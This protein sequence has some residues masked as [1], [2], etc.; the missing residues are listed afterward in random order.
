MSNKYSDLHDNPNPYADGSRSGVVGNADDDDW[1]PQGYYDVAQ[2]RDDDRMKMDAGNPY[3]GGAGEYAP[4]EGNASRYVLDA[5]NSVSNET[6]GR[7]HVAD[8]VNPTTEEIWSDE[9]IND[10][11]VPER[12]RE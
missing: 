12:E 11:A 2:P 9:A 8:D 10:M 4:Y 5:L 6:F 1:S 3:D 7:E